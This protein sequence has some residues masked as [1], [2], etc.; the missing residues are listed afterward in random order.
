MKI[1]FVCQQYIHAARWIGQLK[2]SGNDIYV[3]DCLDAPIHEDLKWTNF[4]T[5]WSKR[6]L[7]YLKGED[8]LKKHFPKLFYLIE[9]TDTKVIV[10]ESGRMFI[11]NICMAFDLRLI[12][13][14]P[15]TR[16]FSMTI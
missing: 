11:R 5:N 12:E 8:W 14:R 15:D 10:K 6:K 1:L 7:P 16:I 13:H 2:D 9:I 3:F 4:T